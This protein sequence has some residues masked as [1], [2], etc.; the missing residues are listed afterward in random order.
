[1]LTYC[2]LIYCKAIKFGN[3]KDAHF[4]QNKKTF[5]FANFPFIRAK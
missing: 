5:H 4:I 2:N 3:N 1:M